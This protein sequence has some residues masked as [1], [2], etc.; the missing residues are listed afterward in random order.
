MVCSSDNGLVLDRDVLLL[1]WSTGQSGGAVWQRKD[2]A[3]PISL[4]S[5]FKKLYMLR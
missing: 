2:S 4:T 1:L 5:N 3:P